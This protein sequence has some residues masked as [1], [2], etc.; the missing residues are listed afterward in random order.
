MKCG[1]C[2]EKAAIQMRHHKLALCK[3]HFLEWIPAQ[4]ERF[5]EKYQM[6][7]QQERLLVAVSGG[8]DSLSLWDILWRLGY[9]ADG[10]YIGLGI[11]GGFG[12]S[13]RIAAIDREIC[14]GTR[15]EAA[16]RK[17]RRGIWTD[18]PRACCRDA[19]R[20]GKTVRGVRI[21]QAPCDEPRRPGG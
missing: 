9:N 14:P 11:D 16:C 17:R 13:D 19:S 6:F 4:T 7:S 1:K 5:I 10:L 18:N 21:D 8:K 20:A 2:G 3:E 15:S 12:Y